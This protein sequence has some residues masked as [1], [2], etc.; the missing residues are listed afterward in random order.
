M[1]DSSS[2]MAPTMRYGLTDRQ[3]E[4]AL[5][6]M[7]RTLAEVASARSTITYGELAARVGQ[8][9]LVAR[10]AGL[11]VLLGEICADEDARRGI[12]LGSVVVR[13]DTG[14]PG[15]GFFRHA[16]ELGRDVGDETAFWRN[17]VCRVWD[18]FA[19]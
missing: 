6:E 11:G 13:A 15:D 8:G 16:A 10:S 2:S 5:V 3:W 9:R 17:E 12:M 14:V 1:P 4:A 19:Q 7:R 18:S